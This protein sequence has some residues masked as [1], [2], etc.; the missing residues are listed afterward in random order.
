MSS[1]LLLVLVVVFSFAIGHL[2]TRRAARFV[3][4]SGVEYALVGLLIGPHFVWRLM[5]APALASFQPLISL[6]LGLLG[7]VL[8]L[9]VRHAMTQPAN[10]G[11]GMLSTLGVIAAMTALLLPLVGYLSPAQQSSGFEFTRS[12]LHLRGYVLELHF[13]SNHLWVA[14]ALASAAGVVSAPLVG[15]IRALHR[16]SGRVTDIVEVAA[17]VSQVVAVLVYGLMLSSTRA[18]SGK[19]PIPM[20][21]V[22]WAVASI[23]TAIV[24]G[25]LFS[26][27]IG[28]ENDSSRVFLATIGLVTFASGVGAAL[29]ISPLFINLLAGVTVAATSAH[30]DRVQEHLERLQHPLFVLIMIFA[31]AHFVPVRGWGWLLPAVYVVARYLLRRLLTPLSLRMLVVDGPRVGRIGH[32]L[33]SQ[34]TLA[35][36]IALDFALQNPRHHALVLGTVLIGA[37]LSDL[38]SDRALASLLADAGETGKAEASDVEVQQPKAAPEVS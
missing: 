3:T 35:V 34:G 9:R 17:S 32:G 29:G 25:L 20:T 8:G 33:L 16:A 22:E 6:L 31:G 2:V 21:V 27:F 37:F 18:S 5:S 13:T 23:G 11:A 15:H 28:R 14:L 24:S 4:L 7:F 38:W 10:A 26:L 36:A 19:A 30:A 1:S 12:L